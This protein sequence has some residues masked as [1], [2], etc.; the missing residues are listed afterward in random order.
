[1]AP[2]KHRG[3]ADRQACLSDFSPV[4][5]TFSK[6]N[7]VSLSLQGKPPTMFVANDKVRVSE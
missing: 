7:E 2:A 3:A 1:M 4:D 6:L 5:N